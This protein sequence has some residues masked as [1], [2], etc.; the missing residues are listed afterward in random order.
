MKLSVFT[1][2]SLRVLMF[3]A[4]REGEMITTQQ[5]GDAFDISYN[6]LVKVVHKLSSS[7]YIEV[8]RGR[9]GGFKL[10]K[11]ASEITLGQVVRDVEP[12]FNLVECHA[13]ESNK[14]AVTSFCRLKKEIDFALG[15][16][17]D[18]LD[19]VT[20]AD[21]VR[22]DQAKWRRLPARIASGA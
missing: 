15:A 14:C 9:Y 20:V 17:I 5:V 4:V 18:R 22:G 3:A 13:R 1:D 8:Q 21:M 7:G 16:F 11:P 19:R 10:A 2:Y 12:D 6:H